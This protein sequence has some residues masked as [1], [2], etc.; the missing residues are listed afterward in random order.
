MLF[1]PYV[2]FHSFIAYWKIAAHSAY[3]ILSKY[4]YLINNLFFPASDFVVGFS[5]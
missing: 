5:F 2:R 1:E 3:D 4:K